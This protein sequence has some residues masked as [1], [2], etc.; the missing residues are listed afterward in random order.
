MQVVG[1]MT[2]CL[3]VFQVDAFTQRPLT[4][5][6]AGVVFNAEGLD[7]A[8]LLAIARELNNADSAFVFAPDAEDHD[9]RVRFFTPRT[10]ATFVGHATLAVHTVLAAREGRQHRMHC[11]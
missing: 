9:L 1:R 10:E 4:G 7:D 6:P 2:R 11:E 8:T 5:N 3:E